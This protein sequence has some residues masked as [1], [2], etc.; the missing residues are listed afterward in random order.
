MDRKPEHFNLLYAARKIKFLF[1]QELVPGVILGVDFIFAIIL[2]IW[3]QPS[4]QIVIFVGVL[5]NQPLWQFDSYEQSM[6]HIGLQNSQN[7]S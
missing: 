4:G 7:C 2:K 5:L 6:S 3:D 1:G